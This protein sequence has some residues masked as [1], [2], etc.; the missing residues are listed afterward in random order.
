MQQGEA[1]HPAKDMVQTDVQCRDIY[2][3]L[4]N[5][6][7]Q[8][9]EPPHLEKPLTIVE[10]LYS[11]DQNKKWSTQHV[12][13][14]SQAGRVLAMS[15][16]SST[17]ISGSDRSFE[18]QYETLAWTMQTHNSDVH[19]TGVN[20]VPGAKDIKSAY[21]SELAGLYRMIVAI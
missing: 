4:L 21:R 6:A 8:P 10:W 20:V 19:L 5:W 13:H 1:H 9:D 11:A 2:R 7:Q 14:S 12:M 3:H 18:E 17:M 16:Q 15:I